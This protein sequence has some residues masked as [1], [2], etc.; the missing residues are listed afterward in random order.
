MVCIHWRTATTN[1]A[2]DITIPLEHLKSL[3]GSSLKYFV[4]ARETGVGWVTAKNS[5]HFG[6]AGHYTAMAEK[7]GVVALI[8]WASSHHQ[9]HIFELKLQLLDSCQRW[10][11]HMDKMSMIVTECETNYCWKVFWG[12]QWPTGRHGLLPPGAAARGWDP[13]VENLKIKAKLQHISIMISTYRSVGLKHH[14]ARNKSQTNYFPMK[15][16]ICFI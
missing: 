3:H 1:L 9:C 8:A 12:W 2:R 13:P 6:I 7:Q 15:I 14:F 16:H 5:N 4:Q 10:T 11:Q